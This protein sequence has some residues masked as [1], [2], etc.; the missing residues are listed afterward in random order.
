MAWAWRYV[1]VDSAGKPVD[2]QTETFPNQG[3]AESWI[4]ENWRAL[5]AKGNVAKVTLLHDDKMIYT[6]SLEPGT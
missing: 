2:V 6:M 5:A 1:D 4:G 3:D